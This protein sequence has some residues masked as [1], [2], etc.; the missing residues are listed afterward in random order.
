MKF[1]Y[2]FSRLTVI[3][4]ILGIAL[5]V[6]G[7]GTN[8]YFLI[9]NDISSTTNPIYYIIRY[10]L[11]FFIP[12]LCLVLLVGLLISSYYYVDEK[13]L[14]TSF[15]IIKSKYDISEIQTIVLDRTTNKLTLVFKN[16]N[17][18]V[19]VVK[20]EWYDEFTAALCRANTDIDFSIK[21]RER[22]DGDDSKKS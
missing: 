2:K 14:T 3:F 15:G 9:V 11:M 10:V 19:I 22:D 20:E 1:K 8:I 17:F 6:V 18:I 7:F 4:I 16:E 21:S 13:T 5:C 12:A